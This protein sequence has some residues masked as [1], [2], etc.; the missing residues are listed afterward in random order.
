MLSCDPTARYLPSGEYCTTSI[1]S[2]ELLFCT[3]ILSSEFLPALI[4]R[5]PSLCPT[6]ICPFLGLNPIPLAHYESATLVKEEAPGLV[7]FLAILDIIPVPVHFL[8]VISHDLTILSSPDDTKY[9]LPAVAN[10]QTSPSAW[11][12]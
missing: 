12:S 3:T 1:H 2:L 6:A 5:V 11:D 4:L 7:T 8:V 10:P 9:P